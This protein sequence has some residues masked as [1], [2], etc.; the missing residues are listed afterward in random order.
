M[1]SCW[2]LSGR[3]PKGLWP[4]LQNRYCSWYIGANGLETTDARIYRIRK[5]WAS[6]T[7][8]MVR[9]ETA[10]ILKHLLALLLTLI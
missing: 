5:D 2:W 10:N 4:D 9:Q 3:R 8:A 7:P 1:D 6:L